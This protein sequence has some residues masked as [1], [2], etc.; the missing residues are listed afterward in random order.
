MPQIHFIQVNGSIQTI[1]APVGLSVMEI[2]VK[3][4]MDKIEGAC[5]G[6][7]AC[8]TC[9]VYVHPDWWDKVMPEEGEM[10]EA[11]DDM[12]DLAFNLTKLSRLSCQIIVTDDLDGL[13]VALPGSKPDWV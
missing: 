5:G 10:S 6:S 9:H 12:L 4:N 11:E 2:A 7:L 3:H 1:D 13:I 8:A